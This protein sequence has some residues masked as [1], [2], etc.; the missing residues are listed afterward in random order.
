MFKLYLDLDY[1]TMRGFKAL[2]FRRKHGLVD[3]DAITFASG[4]AYVRT[5]E[6]DEAFARA[7]FGNSVH[8]SADIDPHWLVPGE[9][10]VDTPFVALNP[11]LT[12]E[13]AKDL[14]VRARFA[15]LEAAMEAAKAVVE[16]EAEADDDNDNS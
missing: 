5:F 7:W 15:E 11:E 3:Y 13:R 8:G 16:A 6:V 2:D 4:P 12:V 14:Y 1:G 10:V 9:L